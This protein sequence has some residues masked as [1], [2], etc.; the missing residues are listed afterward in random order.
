MASP[1]STFTNN[2]HKTQLSTGLHAEA[3]EMELFSR[4]Y[5]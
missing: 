2:E 4:V 5:Q 1:P 3:L